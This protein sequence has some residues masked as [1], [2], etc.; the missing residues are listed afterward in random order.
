MYRNSIYNMCHLLFYFTEGVYREEIKNQT[1]FD[2]YDA[3]IGQYGV[4][5][6]HVLCNLLNT[7]FELNIITIMRYCKVS[8]L[9]LFA[10][11]T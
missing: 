1:G 9:V 4:S 11:V 6:Q 7:L 3:G 8:Q 2:I 5:L 10:A